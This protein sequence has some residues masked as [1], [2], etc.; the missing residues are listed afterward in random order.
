MVFTVKDFL[1]A[2]LHPWLDCLDTHPWRLCPKLEKNLGNIIGRLGD[3]YNSVRGVAVHRDAQVESGTVIKSGTIIGPRCFVASGA[4]LRGGCWLAD[5]CF[6]G[7]GVE[8]KSTII[9]ENSRLAHFNFVGDSIIGSDVNIEAGAIIANFRNECPG[10]SIVLSHGRERIETGMSKFGAVIGDGVRIG[11]NAVIA[12]G[13]LI[14][15]NTVIA[16]L[17]LVDQRPSDAASQ[18]PSPDARYGMSDCVCNRNKQ[19][20]HDARSDHP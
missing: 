4:Y 1:S 12:P 14:C 18:R 3:D 9:G 17:S 8:I 16:R 6:I 11:A 5:G 15:P 2:G 20:P 19:P 10:E 7:P 13:A